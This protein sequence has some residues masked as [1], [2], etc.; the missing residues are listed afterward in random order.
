MKNAVISFLISLTLVVT[1]LN[2][3]AHW[4]SVRDWF[5][6]TIET[7]LGAAFTDI[8]STDVLSDFPTTYNANLDFAANLGE[9]NA[10][11]G[12]NTFSL[13]TQ[14]GNSS[15]TKFSCYGT[16]YFGATAT[17]SISTAGALTLITPLLTASGG[18][19][20]TTL[21]SNQVLLGNGTGNIGVVV[22]L[23]T[24]GQYLTSNG[25]G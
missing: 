2:V 22:G 5:K 21:S 17:S 23:G 12:L 6:P 7:R 4:F 1:A 19:G 13:L 20:S 8:S 15:S 11:T 25:V 24:S 18:T 14:L 9:T 3:P 16:C 10:F